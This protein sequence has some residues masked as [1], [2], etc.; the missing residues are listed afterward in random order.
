MKEELHETYL[1]VNEF[2]NGLL[3]VIQIHGILRRS[4][5]NDVVFVVIITTH[6]GKLFGIREFNVN[7]VLLHDA[8]DAT[9]TNADN[10]LMVSLRNMERDLGRKFFLEQRKTLHDRCIIAGN[11]NQKVV[12]V[13]GLELDLHISCL[14]D[15]I[16]LAVLLSANELAV[17]V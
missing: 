12:F 17:L 13:K 1:G 10:T 8:L 16:D 3:E 5:S 15:L 4:T 7:T 2:H 14:H 6:R 9:T 11:V